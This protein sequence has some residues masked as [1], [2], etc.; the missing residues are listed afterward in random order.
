FPRGPTLDV[1]GLTFTDPLTSL[2]MKGA[3]LLDRRLYTDA[4]AVVHE[5]RLVYETYRNGMTENDRHVAHSCSKTMTT[6]A[7]GI[8][9]EEGR[10]DRSRRIAEYVPELASLPAWDTVTLEHVLD[11]A[12]GID[13]D[14]H[15]EDPS[16]MYWRY[17]EAVGYYTD[18]AAGQGST[19]AF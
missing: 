7:V 18:G 8:A 16:S 2:P 12:T 4:L 15:Y 1:D 13:L 9:S 17:A 10:L 11:M 6:M 5:G 14:E 3:Q 19:L